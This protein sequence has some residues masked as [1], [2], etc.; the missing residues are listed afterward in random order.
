MGK[1]G[2]GGCNVCILAYGRRLQRK[3]CTIVKLTNKRWMANK[4]NGEN[5]F[6]VKHHLYLLDTVHHLDNHLTNDSTNQWGRGNNC[7]LHILKCFNLK[8]TYNWRVLKFQSKMV[9]SDYFSMWSVILLEKCNNS[10]KDPF[11][12]RSL[13]KTVLWM[14]TPRCRLNQHLPLW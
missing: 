12:K 2:K 8:T 10:Q 6:T 11:G 4:V 1:K 13:W 5:H 7:I 9:N 3:Q 14:C